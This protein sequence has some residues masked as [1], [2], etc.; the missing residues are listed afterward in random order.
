MPSSSLR[1]QSFISRSRAWLGLCLG[2]CGAAAGAAE[3]QWRH[4]SS[5]TGDLALPGTST[6]QTGALVSDLDQDGKNDFVLSFRKVAPALVW[7]RRVADKWD[8]IVIDP[9][10]LTV[11]AGGVAYD[12]DGDGDLDLVFGADFQGNQVWWW[13]NPFPHYAPGVPWQRHLIKNEGAK[14][15][16]DQI[17]AD[18]LGTG[19]PQ[20]VFWNQ[21]AKKLF[22]AEIPADPRHADSWPL[23]QI[24]GEM[25][26]DVA[27]RGEF[28]YVE[29]LAAADVD[30]DG[31]VDLLAGNMWF[32]LRPG[33]K[34]EAIPIGTIGGRIAAAK[35]KPGKSPQIVIAPGDG[36][37]PLRIY[38]CTGNPEKPA[39][40]VG[41]DLAGRDL[42]HG[43]TLQI[44]D[45]DGDGHL[46]IFAAE[47]AKWTSG[48][49]VDNPSATSWIFYGDGK[50]GFRQ[51][52]FTTGID[53][54]E[55]KV[56]DLDGDGRLDILDK[57]YTWETPRVD[58]WLQ[59]PTGPRVGATVP[60]SAGAVGLEL[61]SF[62]NE[63]TKD[64]AGTLAKAAALGFTDVEVPQLF[65]QTAPALREE[66][67]R[68]GLTTSA[69]VAGYAALGA[70]LDAVIRDARAL[71]AKYVI[72][73][74]FSRKGPMTEQSMQAVARDFN[75]WGAR[76]RAAGLQFCYHPHGYEFVPWRDG[77]LFDLLVQSTEP[78]DVAFE[79]DVFW[80][81]HPGQDPVALLQK[82]PGRFAL[83]HLKDLQK[84]L[85]GDLS[86]KA[87][88]VAS[89]PLGEGQA[90]WP[91]IIRAA[92]AAGVQR[93]YIE[94]EAPN[95]L[96]QVAQS[97]RYLRETPF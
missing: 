94:D 11:E 81:L 55:G 39:D 79:L 49:E 85:H 58:V 25:A 14:M 31:H 24:A 83:M 18:F 45:I 68:A 22:L 82:Y 27:K 34:F 6:E 32:K 70:D 72:N 15:H 4:L 10:F 87:P 89:V 47:M 48:K 51:T 21:K 63:L 80:V 19:K 64:F 52:V 33:R 26:D 8:R 28:K 1:I 54:H 38:E 91:A 5:A 35:F 40:W 16:H 92:E 93:Y 41:R 84:G 88:E 37:G 95:A 44:A 2:L 71:G 66:L 23:V 36:I 17:F 42:I 60:F 9:E 56:A 30:G 12:I 76:L 43:H 90:N 20:L 62:R 67:N 57:P 61:Y 59:V 50:G 13:E 97:L 46:D 53:W 65:G 74:W 96:T 75:A 73:G 7:F 3:P 78:R 29:G 77:T 69:Y 86:G